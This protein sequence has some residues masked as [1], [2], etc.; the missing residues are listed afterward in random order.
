MVRAALGQSLHL[1]FWAVFLTAVLT[2]LLATLVPSV[3]ITKPAEV[4][5][6]E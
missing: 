6:A 5:I 2:L 4:V 1:T 3:A